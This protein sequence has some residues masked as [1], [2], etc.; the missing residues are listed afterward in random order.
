MEKHHNLKLRQSKLSTKKNSNCLEMTE[1]KQAQSQL[2]QG[3]T[4]KDHESSSLTNYRAGK[5]I[6]WGLESEMCRLEHMIVQVVYCTK[7][8][9]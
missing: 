9:H 6:P 8:P 4:L 5:T 7:A 3:Q 1:G 2:F